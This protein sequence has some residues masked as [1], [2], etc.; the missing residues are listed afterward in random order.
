MCVCTKDKKCAYHEE[1]EKSDKEFEQHVRRMASRMFCSI[2]IKE[3]RS[4]EFS[5]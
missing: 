4:L 5:K 1:K 2:K 3:D